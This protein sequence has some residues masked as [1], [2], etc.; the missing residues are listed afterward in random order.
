MGCLWEVYLVGEDRSHLEGAARE[1]LDEVERLDRQLSHTRPESDICRLNANAY[2]HWVRLEPAL[3]SILRRCAA[4][5]EETGGSFDVA[6][7]ALLDAWGYLRS[8]GYVPS[9]EEITSALARSGLERVAFDDED[10][11][12]HFPVEGMLIALGAVGKGIGADAAA[13][14]LRFYGIEAAVLHGGS[15][16]IYALGAPPGEDGWKFEARS[17]GSDRNRL[18][19]FSLRDRALSTSSAQEQFVQVGDRRL[20]HIMDP[21]TGRPAEG[22]LS[23]WVAADAATDSDALSTALFVMGREAAIAFCST[24]PELEVVL[25]EETPG[26]AVTGLHICGASVTPLPA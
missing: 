12:V 14:T 24:R 17:P 23:V 1:A 25:A 20:G 8:S 2:E 3:Y 26:G 6:C 15:S 21:R 13:R 10:H 5:H 22:L 7:G 9:D 19:T 4:L 16:T 18:H 11:C